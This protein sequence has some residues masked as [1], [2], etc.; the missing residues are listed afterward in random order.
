M[1]KEPSLGICVP[2]YPS[3]DVF[4]GNMHAVLAHGCVSAQVGI[5]TA[6]QNCWKPGNTKLVGQD[7]VVAVMTVEMGSRCLHCSHKLDGGYFNCGKV[8]PGHL[9]T[10]RKHLCFNTKLSPAGQSG[11]PQ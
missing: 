6:A 9:Q 10:A 8:S 5:S 2:R 3:A 1:Y 4:M 11:A 7:H